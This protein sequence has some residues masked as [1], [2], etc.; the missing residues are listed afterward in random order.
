MNC[1]LEKLVVNKFGI[2]NGFV[3]IRKYIYVSK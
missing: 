2:S 3:Y 1:E